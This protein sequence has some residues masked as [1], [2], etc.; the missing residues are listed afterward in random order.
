VVGAFEA[1]DYVLAQ[2]VRGALR[3][4]TLA[5]F[6]DID[7]LALPS[8]AGPPPR[9]SELEEAMGFVDPVALDAASRY[10]YVASLCGNPAGTAPVGFDDQGL[11]LGL[12]LIGDVWDEASVLQTM[13][14]LERL[15]VAQVK[16]PT[17]YQDLLNS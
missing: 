14:H 8:T 2:R 13:A 1:D 10:A 4:E 15:E 17:G 5:L 12:Q 3:R 16:P 9:V 7:L 11:P 6:Q